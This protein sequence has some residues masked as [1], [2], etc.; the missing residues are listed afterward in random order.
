MSENRDVYSNIKDQMRLIERVSAAIPGF[1]GYKEKELR[2]ESDKLLR[3]HLG[4]K[5]SAIKSDIQKIFQKL[6]DRRYLDVLTD[7][8]RLVAK[9]DRVNE[10][11]N[12][13][14]YG[15]TGFFDS[16]KVKENNLDKMI[17]FDTQLI[18][19]INML[20][21]EVDAFSAEL[22][23]G[24]NKNMRNRIQLITDKVESLESEFDKREQ[25]ILGV[26]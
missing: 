25:I 19:S 26:I 7:M 20:T 4:Q 21:S 6:S 23:S 22:V 12:H 16:V 3:N 11:I 24:E 5:V 1:R 8:D 18:N 10:K 9:I 15:Y 2:R 13:A 17:D 14:S